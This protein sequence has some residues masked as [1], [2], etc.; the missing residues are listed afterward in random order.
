MKK[1]EMMRV[2]NTSDIFQLLFFFFLIEAIV[3]LAFDMCRTVFKNQ[4]DNI[5][6]NNTFPDYVA[7]LV[8]FS[9]NKNFAK[10]SLQSIEVL[11]QSISRM[12]DFAKSPSGLKFLQSTM[13]HVPVSVLPG[14]PI[15]SSEDPDYRFWFPLLFGLYEIIMTGDL[16]VRTRGLNYL[17]DT[18]KVYG[19]GFSQDFWEVISKG[20]LF[21][22]FDDLK[23]SRSDQTK[24]D[25]REDMSVWLSTTLI[26]ALRNFIDLFSY[27]FQTLSFLVDG[28]LDLLSVCMTQ[29]ELFNNLYFY[30]FFGNILLSMVFMVILFMLKNNFIYSFKYLLEN[31]TLARIGSTCLQ[32]FIEGNVE[33]LDPV[34][35]DK[36]CNTFI[37]LF[38]M[39]TPKALFDF[40]NPKNSQSGA[41]NSMEMKNYS[42]ES[43]PIENEE[44]RSAEFPLSPTNDE[45]LITASN[46][47]EQKKAFN[48]ITV[49]CVLH[50]LVIQTLH[51]VLNGPNDSVYLSLSTRHLFILIDCLERS[52][53]FAQAF[54]N[55]LEL[56][57][58]LHRMGFMKQLPNLLK[59]ETSAVSGYIAALQ[60]MYADSSPE[61]HNH[62]K[63]IENRLIP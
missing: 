31:E 48:Q 62:R 63:E 22:I 17:F 2:I 51:E 5:I 26:Q 10:T 30:F 50:L 56:R 29:G 7:C 28:V 37:R 24:F 12:A 46:P 52:Y 47:A 44:H 58:T 11:R 55:D 8:E 16:E 45:P 9:K 60:R 27:H 18:L 43:L 4:F 15:P 49:K 19:K 32:Q 14:G 40:N 54:N 23:M 57:M 36:I 59:Q 33:K 38:S 25:N 34:V 1:I 61:R 20:V 35:W 41:K 42:T 3:V 21:P 53:R 39:T 13:D 6:N